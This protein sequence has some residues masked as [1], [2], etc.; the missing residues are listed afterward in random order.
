MKSKSFYYDKNFNL[1]VEKSILEATEDLRKIVDT[2]GELFIKLAEKEKKTYDIIVT[3]IFREYLER[4][5]GTLILFEK[6]SIIN[7]KIILRSAIE[8]YGDLNKILFDTSELNAYSYLVSKWIPKIRRSKKIDNKYVNS[9]SLEKEVNDFI[10]KTPLSEKVDDLKDF[11]KKQ[12]KKKWFEY[13][14]LIYKEEE[15]YNNLYKM[16]CSEVHGENATK[17]FLIKDKS[18]LRRPLRCSEDYELIFLCVSYYSLL[19]YKNI[20]NK[21]LF[22]EFE[23]GEIEKIFS[24]Y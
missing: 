12:K 8:I 20:I 14:K 4:I 2:G 11:K 5:D 3:N 6:S 19:L 9:D 7:S 10:R 23:I 1:K 15:N 17:E 24:D 22:E 21:Y 16:L 13:G 18:I